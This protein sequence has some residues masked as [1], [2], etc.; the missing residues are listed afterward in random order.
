[1][2]SGDSFMYIIAI[3]VMFVVSVYTQYLINPEEKCDNSKLLE[4][5][6]L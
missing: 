4:E 1:M 2:Y 6:N 5:S 3:F